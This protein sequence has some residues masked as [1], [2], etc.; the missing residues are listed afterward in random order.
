MSEFCF[1]LF[2]QLR[3]RTGYDGK[4]LQTLVGTAGIQNRARILRGPF[5]NPR[6]ERAAPGLADEFNVL[7][8]IASRAHGPHHVEQIGRIH[9]VIDNHDEATQIGP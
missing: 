5:R 2:P 9:V 8:R 6:I 3:A 4:I 1:D 7:G